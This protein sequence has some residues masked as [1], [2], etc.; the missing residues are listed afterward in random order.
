MSG[1]HREVVDQLRWAGCVYADDE[2]RLII[3]TAAGDQAAMNRLLTRRCSGEPLEL[4]VGFADFAGVRVGVVPGVF[5]PRVRSEGLVDIAAELLGGE[6][7]SSR[8]VVDLGCGTGA[9]LMAVLARVDCTAYAVDS[10]PVA[11]RVAAANLAG[12]GVTVLLGDLLDPLP[13]SIRGRVKVVLANLPY[14]PTDRMGTLPREARLYEPA[15]VLDGGVDGLL[16][17]GRALATAGDWLSADGTYLCELDA[18]Q[19]AAA[20]AVAAQHGF[21]LDAQRDAGTSWALVRLRRVRTAS[22]PRRPVAPVPPLPA[23][24]DVSATS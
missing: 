8:I 19:L 18:G 1:T 14:V 23:A 22:G 10:D 20:E 13:G 11:V 7:R 3:E 15:S 12:S 9:L 16:P 2:A 17:L 24:R 21:V 6:D 5:L 4:V